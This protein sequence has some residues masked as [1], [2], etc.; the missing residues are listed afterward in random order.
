VTMSNLLGKSRFDSPLMC[1]SQ[2][3]KDFVVQDLN[4]R[5]GNSF[6]LLPIFSHMPYLMVGVEDEAEV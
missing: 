6:M 3:S 5:S 1:T 2:Q 4:Q